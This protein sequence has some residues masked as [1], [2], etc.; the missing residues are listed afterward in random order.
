[1]CLALFF[2]VSCMFLYRSSCVFFCSYSAACLLPRA[3]LA[4][5]SIM[6]CRSRLP[7][8]HTTLALNAICSV[9]CLGNLHKH[10]GRLQQVRMCPQLICDLLPVFHRCWGAPPRPVACRRLSCTLHSPALSQSLLGVDGS[11]VTDTGG[12]PLG[13]EAHHLPQRFDSHVINLHLSSSLFPKRPPRARLIE[14]GVYQ[15][16]WSQPCEPPWRLP[17]LQLWLGFPL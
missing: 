6:L 4:Y 14:L 10:I 9:L 3:A 5:L 15:E 7:V 8:L 13:P 2:H 16:V 1:M 11:M 12:Q 17:A